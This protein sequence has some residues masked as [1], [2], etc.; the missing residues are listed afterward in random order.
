MF[1]AEEYKDIPGYEGKYQISNLGKI[2]SLPKTWNTTMA[3]RTS[4][5][6]ILK[7]SKDRKG[8]FKVILCK[9]PDEHKTERVHRLL[10]ITFIENPD[11]KQY[12]NHIDGNKENNSLDNLEWVT[13]QENCQHAQDTGLNKARYS[14]KQKE[15]ARKTGLSN[16]GRKRKVA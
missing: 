5:E 16:K 3:I 6:R 14:T 7:Q 10:A 8:Y 12:I 13:H 9:S 1:T 2:K 11:N 4:K 15:A